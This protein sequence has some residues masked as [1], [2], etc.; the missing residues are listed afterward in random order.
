MNPLTAVSALLGLAI[1]SPGQKTQ[2]PAELGRATYQYKMFHSGLQIGSAN[3]VR[4]STTKGRHTLLT[5]NET[6][7]GNTLN[8]VFDTLSTNDGTPEKKVFHG[9]LGQRP[10]RSTAIFTDAGVDFEVQ[11]AM[12]Q[13]QKG[14]VKKPVGATLADASETWFNGTIPKKGDTASF[15]NFNVQN[16]KWELT[17]TTYVGDEA[18]KVGKTTVQAHH[19]HVKSEGGE[20]DM[21]LDDS[22]DIVVMDQLGSLRMER[23]D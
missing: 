8:A 7:E 12:G 23:A 14:T 1:F 3:Y 4:V 5:I 2:D 18:T 6:V 16:G 9:V 10:F 20:I 22:A 19:L 17:S 21:F 15:T 13:T 11:D